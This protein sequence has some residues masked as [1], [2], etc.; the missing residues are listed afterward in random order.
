[1]H[2][3]IQHDLGRQAVRF[4]QVPGR[5]LLQVTVPELLDTDLKHTP[6]DSIMIMK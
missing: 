4:K 2:W 5:N 6:N 1:M 3:L